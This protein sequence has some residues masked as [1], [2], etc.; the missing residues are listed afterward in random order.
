MNCPKSLLTKLAILAMVLNC[1]DIM[2]IEEAEYSVIDQSGD[3][4]LR[5]YAG[6]IV[7][8]TLVEDEFEDAG[9]RAFRPLFKYISGDN[10]SSEEISMTSPVPQKKQSEKIAMTAP[11]S[12]TESADGWAV[13][14]MMPA[15]YTMETIPQPTNSAVS[16]R[17][18]PAFRAAV[19]RF[20]GRWTEKNYAEHL[21]ELQSWITDKQLKIDGE[22]IWA[23]YNPP[24]KPWF[25]RRNEILIPVL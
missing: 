9:N 4:E 5:D 8:E 10:Q 21:A 11:V 23:R 7:A 24:F 17:E 14:F 12:Q 22:P 13:S 25:M 1:G 16:I 19:I 2:A 18:V 15:D 3:F 6:S 20:S